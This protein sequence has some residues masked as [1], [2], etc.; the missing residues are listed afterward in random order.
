MARTHT[1]SLI[2]WLIL[3]R[4]LKAYKQ[5]NVPNLKVDTIFQIDKTIQL[6]RHKF[7]QYY[8]S[9]ICL[10]FLQRT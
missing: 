8:D 6:W 7:H 4:Y 9:F 1:H 3:Q 5:G 2:E 10:I